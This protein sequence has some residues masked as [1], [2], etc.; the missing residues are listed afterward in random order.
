MVPEHFTKRLVNQAFAVGGMRSKNLPF[1]DDQI[2]SLVKEFPT[3]FHVYYEAGIRSAAQNLNQAFDWVDLVND[4]GYINYFAVKAT[5]N[6]YILE[7]LKEE[8]MGA[9]ASSGPEIELASAVGLKH[10][11][12]I[13]TSNNTPPAEYAEAYAAGAILNLD[14][15]TQIEVLQNALQGE[16]P[17]TISFRY[18]PGN[19][20]SIGVNGIIGEPEDA[21]FGILDS[22]L[23]KACRRA[24]ELGVKHFGIHTMVASNELDAEQHIATARIVFEKVL[25]LNQK[26]GII[27]EFANLG[28]GLGIPYQPDQNPVDYAQLKEGITQ[29][30]KELISDN[31]L[32]PL[33]VVT[34]NGRHV[35]GPNGFLVARVRN[36][37]DKHHRYVGLDANMANLMRPGMYD[38]Y[39]HI[40][41]IGKSNG[42]TAMQRVVGDL[43]ENND[44]FTGSETKE[45]ELPLMEVGDIVVI[46]DTGAH[47]HAM[48]F[49]YNGKLR[50]AEI[51]LREDGSAKLIRTAETR[52]NLFATMDYPGLG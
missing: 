47:G 4:I 10:P 36:V 29:A 40:S 3:P 48:G 18:N 32:Q 42:E 13:F 9:D 46:H 49:N 44:H 30:Y 28:G 34:E 27:F 37:Y 23:E 35:T 31:G 19:K 5:P 6:P 43:C 1:S 22:Q 7:I 41:V 8:G 17:D 24:Q 26:L 12:I 2:R 38:A 52:K 16:F 25:E 51:L 45:R 50:S 11:Y 33:R 39:H 21:K 14:D 15:I 20:K